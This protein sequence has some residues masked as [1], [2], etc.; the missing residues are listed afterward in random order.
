VEKSAAADFCA[1]TNQLAGPPP[2]DIK[3]EA[4]RLLR[5][6]IAS[7][8]KARELTKLQRLAPLDSKKGAAAHS[9]M[10]RLSSR[11]A[12]RAIG[13]VGV[14]RPRVWCNSLRKMKESPEAY[15]MRQVRK[16]S[17]KSN[18]RGSNRAERSPCLGQPLE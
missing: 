5:S 10:P 13:V 6:I 11:H 15:E 9:F 2:G 3:L 7:F 4:K 17:E 8:E 1:M 14:G 16:A 12:A 18:P